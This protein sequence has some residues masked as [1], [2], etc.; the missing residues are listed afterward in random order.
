[1]KSL[2]RYG[3]YYT[4]NNRKSTKLDTTTLSSDSSL[5][6]SG[7]ATSDINPSWKSSNWSSNFVSYH[8]TYRI[9]DKFIKRVYTNDWYRRKY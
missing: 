5:W 4:I 3:H 9:E 7:I 2:K 6:I 8:T 1:M